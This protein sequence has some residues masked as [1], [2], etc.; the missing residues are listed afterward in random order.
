MPICRMVEF[1]VFPDHSINPV[2]CAVLMVAVDSCTSLEELFPLSSSILRNVLA[3][4]MFNDKRD[5]KF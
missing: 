1:L 5:M 3:V 2:S 4:T